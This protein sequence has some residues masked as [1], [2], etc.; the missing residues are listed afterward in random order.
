MITIPS[1]ILRDA[2]AIVVQ[3]GRRFVKGNCTDY[4][5]MMTSSLKAK[6]SGR[7]LKTVVPGVE[8]ICGVHV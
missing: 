1:I 4:D 3:E 7:P 5:V 6:C 8:I 2:G